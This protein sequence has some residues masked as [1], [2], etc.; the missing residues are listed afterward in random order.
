VCEIWSTLDGAPVDTVRWAVMGDVPADLH[1]EVVAVG[2]PRV[3][4]LAILRTYWRLAKEGRIS[5]LMV[6]AELPGGAYQTAAVS[7]TDNL[8]ERVGRLR[9]IRALDLL[10]R[11]LIAEGTEGDG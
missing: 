9:L 4:I 10:E 6:I 2:D 1:L 8:A 3:E 7:S 11:E 5:G